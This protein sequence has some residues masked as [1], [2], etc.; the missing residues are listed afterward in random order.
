[1]NKKI[2]RLKIINRPNTIILLALTII[3]SLFI[4]AVPMAGIAGA[5]NYY[6][7][8]TGTDDTSHGTGTGTGAF[9][10]IQYAVNDSRVVTGDTINVAAGIYLE[11]IDITK[12]NLTIQSV[13]G[14]PEDTVIQA[15]VKNE[16]VVEI[17]SCSGVSF[18]SFTVKG[19]E[20]ISDAEVWGV[21]MEDTQNC[22][23]SNIV[24]TTIETSN[25]NM[26]GLKVGV[27]DQTQRLSSGNSF[28][29]FT[30]SN[31]TGTSN[32]YGIS[33]GF[34]D[35]NTFTGT[36]I[37]NLNNG[38]I[39]AITVIDSYNNTFETTSISDIT[40]D[41][42][43]IGIFLHQYSPYSAYNNS[44]TDTTINNVIA[45]TSSAMGVMA[46]AYASDNSFMT[47]TIS[48]ITSQTSDAF[49]I[50]AFGMNDDNTY[51]NTEISHV[52]AS[53][54]VA[55]GIYF[56]FPGNSGNVFDTT[57]ITD[58]EGQTGAAGIYLYK[59]DSNNVFTFTDISD[60]TASN[61]DSCGIKL[62][63]DV[64]GNSFTGGSITG[65]KYGV[66][67]LGSVADG[68]ASNNSIYSSD[69]SGNTNYGVL[70][71]NVSASFDA[72]NNWWGNA[73]GPKQAITNVSAT[74]DEVSDNV[75]YNPWYTDEAMTTLSN[76]DATLSD[77]TV[78][79]I[80]ISGFDSPTFAYNKVLPY[81]T[82][83]VPTVAATPTDPNASKVITQATNF[84]GT[85]AER[86]ATILVTAED[87]TTTKT[88]KVIFGSIKVT[89]TKTGP[90]T[91]DQGNN[92]TYTITY[93]NE[94]TF[95]ATNV[96]VT[97]T[98]PT[99]V[100]YVSAIP[101]PDVTTNNKWTI[102]N[103]ASEQEGTITVTVH[104]K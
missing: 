93:K 51:D 37:S 22:L 31:I 79:G 83:E 71:E 6:V 23:L 84:T 7:D 63:Y 32:T 43:A 17:T 5:T 86:T 36:T 33:M 67:L 100:E 40:A 98:Y 34:S 91:A 41:T 74:G 73:S 50:F 9:K 69:I 10:T 68:D 13:S 82:T 87:G 60:V 55:L 103:L 42:G 88:Y 35:G 89:I 52:T 30:I 57:T 24:I 14:D 8:P 4:I 75:D 15:N 27:S 54:G 99:E 39:Q 101:A 95:D 96:V 44:F 81:E 59:K 72:T 104:I 48:N 77:L 80:T 56:N 46:Q 76:A 97:E 66:Y 18:S 102:G 28:E 49:G 47:T 62:A 70:N 78:D 94:G 16:N 29:S 12:D 65:T 3:L 45:G 85:E 25:G 1:M 26:G 21:S 20:A 58:I 64:T 2:I 38:Y 53:A 92:I 90:T 61:G 11:T 19:S